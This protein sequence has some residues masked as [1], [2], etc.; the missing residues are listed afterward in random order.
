MLLNFTG[1]VNTKLLLE[2]IDKIEGEYEPYNLPMCV[3]F[4]HVYDEKFPALCSTRSNA[5]NANEITFYITSAS[6]AVYNQADA[7]L[8][9]RGSYFSLVPVKSLTVENNFNYSV[10]LALEIFTYGKESFA[11]MLSKIKQIYTELGV[12][13]Q[14][15]G[16]PEKGCLEFTVNGI[17]VGKINSK[18]LVNGDFLTTAT[19]LHEPVFSSAKALIK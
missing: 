7:G 14:L 9:K 5:D 4:N 11:V 13:Y 3:D 17:M 12:P 2:V 10:S 15:E 1:I 18:K 6:Q 16:D 8:I 19:V